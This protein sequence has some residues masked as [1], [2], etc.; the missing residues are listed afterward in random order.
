MQKIILYY[1][2]TP[3]LDPKAVMLWQKSVTDS[4]GL[5][6]RIII[7]KDGINGT[8]AGPIE[9]VKAYIK[10]NKQ[11]PNFKDIKYKW[12]ESDKP[13]IFPKM[14]VKVRDEIVTFNAQAELKVDQ[15]GV[16]GGGQRIK[17]SQLQKLI[18]TKGNVIFFDGRNQ[19]EAKVGRFKGAIIPA[20]NRTRDFIPLLDSGQYD[21]LKD[22]PIV[23]YCTGGIR[24]E[25]LSML[26]RNRGFKEVYQLEGGIVEYGRLYA[27]QDL[28]EGSVYVFDGRMGVKFSSQAKDIGRCIHCQSKTSQYVNCALKSCNELVLICQKCVLDK[29]RQFHSDACA[30]QAKLEVKPLTA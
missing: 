19:Y 1:K 25:V 13:Q 5:K 15:T 29:Q 11:L 23:T 27:D 16:I 18:K 28:W 4:L 3:I 30:R 7:S 8:L 10:A 14:S 20:V 12:G 24:C 9:S 21:H 22:Q 2:F 6:G 26:M 17:P